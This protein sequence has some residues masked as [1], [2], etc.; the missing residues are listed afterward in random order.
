MV[1]KNA[2]RINK[3]IVT[4]A[5]EQ[6]LNGPCAP[7]GTS[8]HYNACCSGADFNGVCSWPDEICYDA[9]WPIPYPDDPVYPDYPYVNH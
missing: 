1:D 4:A 3:D 7:I 6:P 2:P 5:V 9:G 8:C